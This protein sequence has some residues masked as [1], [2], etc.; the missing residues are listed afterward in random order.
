MGEPNPGKAVFAILIELLEYKRIFPSNDP[1]TI[2]PS[3]VEAK[4]W[5]FVPLEN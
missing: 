3:P 4:H 5:K 1:T 2:E